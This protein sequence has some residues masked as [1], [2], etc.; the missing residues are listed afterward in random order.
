M[1]PHNSVSNRMY[2]TERAVTLQTR[3]IDATNNRTTKKQKWQSLKITSILQI[4]PDN[5]GKR[6]GKMAIGIEFRSG[7]DSE[8]RTLSSARYITHR[9]IETVS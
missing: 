3:V 6:G 4:P 8:C 2:G 5:K 7:L 1:T 9:G